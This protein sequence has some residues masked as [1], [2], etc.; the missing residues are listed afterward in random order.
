MEPKY[1]FRLYI[2]TALI[3]AGCGLLIHRLYQFQIVNQKLYI[4]N[5]PTTHTVTIYEPG[6]R[7]EIID[8][9]GESLATNTR[10]YEI[11]FNLE[12][13]FQ[14]WKQENDEQTPAPEIITDPTDENYVDPVKRKQT[15]I[16]EI[17][18]TWLMPRLNKYGLQSEKRFSSAI[19]AHY[20]AHGG[21]V[22]FRY[23]VDLS[24]DEFASL[25]ENSTH[26]PGVSVNVRARRKYPFGTLACHIL[27]HLAEWQKDNIPEEFRKPRI[28]YMGEDYGIAGVEQTMNE[29]LTGRRGKKVIVRNEKNVVKKL[30]DY[31]PPEIGA[32]I[33]LTIDA[34][35]QLLAEKTLRKVGRG[36]VVIMDPNT[37]E[38]LAMA[39]VPNYDPNDFIPSITPERWD[40][41][42]KNRADPFI[43]R[44][45]AQFTPGSTFK[46]PVALAGCMHGKAGFH[47]N[48]IGYNTYGPSVKIR[49]WKTHGHGTLGLESAIQQSCNPYFM[50]LATSV[51]TQNTVKTFG[52]LGLG[53]KSGIRLPNES[54]GIVPGSTAW[55]REIKPGETLS[56][57]GLA[58]VGI[59]QADS[60][61]T[62]LQICSIAA[63]IA[64]GGRYYQPRI[65]RRAYHPA[66]GPFE[67]RVLIEN[68]PVVKENLLQ[69]GLSASELKKIQHG[70]WLAANE[71]GGTARRASLPNIEVAAKTGTAQTGQ[72]DH[73]D[74]NNAW[75]AAYAPYDEPRYAVVVMVRNGRSG[76]KVAGSLVHYIMRGLFA[77]EANIAPRLAPMGLYAGNFDAYEEVDLP[78]ENSL[79]FAEDNVGETGDE[80]DQNLLTD[81]QPVK[82]K[83]H[84]KPEPTFAP[85]PDDAD[86]TTQE[87]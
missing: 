74:K 49:C 26:L 29:L 54:P 8:R 25:A 69:N 40:A 58:Q 22:P 43:N 76:G 81:Q 24:Y 72:P 73:L 34:R 45:I 64:N 57:A 46:L 21:L 9:H 11:L 4:G 59:G 14:A 65:I 31:Q 67:E 84:Q 44:A 1:R 63:T 53:R 56:R 5:I 77:M 35:I 32:R 6:I 80:L 37:G 12:E 52:L 85:V 13:I 86:G 3:I 38:I 19:R 33:Q 10:N 71:P 30:D 17:V 15:Q 47:C 51:G 50:D 83:P 62:P 55:S 2:L 82:V 27:G 23:P 68:I 66:N 87:D 78:E 41:Y 42:N 16:A 28:H 70:M 60:M 61:A 18:D 36:A 39:S 79:P 75:T 7:G 20:I 48:C